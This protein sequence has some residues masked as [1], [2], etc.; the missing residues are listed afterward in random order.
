VTIREATG[1]DEALLHELWLELEAEIP[2]PAGFG[3]DTWDVDWP[4]LRE[5][6]ERGSVVVAEDE[7]GP[8]GFAELGVAQPGRW[9]LET[10]YVRPQARRQGVATALLRHGVERAQAAGV[11]H[12]S[13]DVVAAN[14]VAR[15]V[16]ER[17]GFASVEI[18]YAAPVSALV[19]RLARGGAAPSRATTHVQSDDRVSVERA[20][21]AF[22]PRLGDVTIET[23]DRGWIRVVDP[24]LD[25]D[26]DAQS[27]LARELAER[28][29]TVAVA[30]AEEEGAVVRFR[31]YDNGRMVDEYLSVPTWYGPLPKGDELALAANPTL[32]ARLTGAD[33]GEVRRVARTATSPAELPPAG[34]LFA[35]IST[36]LGLA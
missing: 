30:L 32:V 19:P 2:E 16:W 24:V 3:P 4:A 15:A 10:I 35:S 14:D 17:L 1:A 20:V 33:A 18:T 9:H 5:S 8:I 34:E 11:E 22:A 12:L 23:S 7:S 27:R 25:A 13:L 29:G 21:A 6:M 28:L 26:R 36:L 31:L